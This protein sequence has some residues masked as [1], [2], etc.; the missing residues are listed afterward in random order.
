VSHCVASALCR[1]GCGSACA[2][3]RCLPPSTDGVLYSAGRWHR[4]SPGG[5]M[6]PIPGP[7]QN[8]GISSALRTVGYCG[9]RLGRCISSSNQRCRRTRTYRKPSSSPVY[10]N[11]RPTEFAFFQQTQQIRAYLFG[12]PLIR[13]LIVILG[14]SFHRLD[15]TSNR[16]LGTVAG[17]NS[18]IILWRSFVMKRPPWGRSCVMPNY[19]I[20][21]LCH[22]CFKLPILRGALRSSAVIG[23]CS[24]IVGNS[25]RA[26]IS[27]IKN[28][29]SASVR[30]PGRVGAHLLGGPKRVVV[31]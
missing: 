24:W 31:P 26:R 16:L 1:S 21:E 11:R 18:S 29:K 5:P 2:Y 4:E 25:E 28:D 6:L 27:R 20:A 10:L 30:R 7:L 3:C 8:L 23:T 14:K 15:I 22:G 12:I 13:A 9:R 19:D 17:R